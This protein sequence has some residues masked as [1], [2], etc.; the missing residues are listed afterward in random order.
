ML[1]KDV[2]KNILVGYEIDRAYICADC[3]RE[4]RDGFL[5]TDNERGVTPVYVWDRGA[6]QACCSRCAYAFLQAWNKPLRYEQIPLDPTGRY[7]AIWAE[8][9]SAAPYRVYV[10][11]RK[12]SRTVYGA[13]LFVR[14]FCTVLEAADWIREQ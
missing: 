6:E 8:A 12:E 1:L 5:P 7:Y 9:D 13:P 11:D 4:D 14:W 2:Q 3:A 10:W